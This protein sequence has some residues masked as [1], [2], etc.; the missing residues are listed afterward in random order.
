MMLT[1]L[2]RDA[3]GCVV[4]A[5]HDRSELFVT[6]K[7]DSGS[8]YVMLVSKISQRISTA[9]MY[10]IYVDILRKIVSTSKDMYTHKHMC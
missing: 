8:C 10:I 5:G 3:Q 2:T 6:T 1:Q 9:Y 7:V 4:M